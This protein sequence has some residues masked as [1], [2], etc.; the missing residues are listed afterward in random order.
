MPRRFAASRSTLSR[1]RWCAARRSA[2]RFLR[3]SPEPAPEDRR[4]R[5]CRRCRASGRRCRLSACP[6]VSSIC[7]RRLTEVI[8]KRAFVRS[9]VECHNFHFITPLIHSWVSLAENFDALYDLFIARGG[10]VQTEGVRN[11][12]FICEECRARYAQ[13]AALDGLADKRLR[14][15]CPR[16]GM[17]WRTG[18]LPVARN[19][20]AG[21]NV[22]RMVSS[23][24]LA[25]FAVDAARLCRD[26]TR[27]SYFVM[28]SLHTYW[29]RTLECTSVVCL[30]M[31]SGMVSDLS[32]TRKPR[33]NAGAMTLEKLPGI[34]D[35]AFGV[36]RLDGRD[37]LTREAQLAVGIVLEDGDIVPAGKLIDLFAL[38]ERGRDAGGILEGRN[39]IE[40]LCVRV[41]LQRGLESAS[42]SMPSLLHRHADELRAVGTE[43]IQ[44]ADKCRVS[45]RMTSPSLTSTLVVRSAHC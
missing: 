33:R 19:V 42:M 35:A 11:L 27:K 28:Y 15:P 37:I 9:G 38:F 36:H 29:N 39:G 21:W 17:P 16:A 44:T 30:A 14:N 43:G 40:Q 13:H 34:Q 45:V 26:A 32:K 3:A 5:K 8:E 2:R 12:L 7:S 4:C 31:V 41:R 18:R 22:R 10:I 20:T 6:A 23:I 24:S 1:N 25:L